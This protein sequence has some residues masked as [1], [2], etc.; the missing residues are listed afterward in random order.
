M[1]RA[2]RKDANHNEIAEAFSAF[3]FEVFDTSATGNGFPDMVVWRPRNGYIL[4][5]V[6]DGL[7]VPSA[8]RLT[9]AE[10]NFSRRFP[11][12]VVYRV[13]DVVEIANG[14]AFDVPRVDINKID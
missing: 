12:A 6:K 4:V 3:G 8:R 5:E 11:V 14:S 9:Q 7:K 13:S 2:R 10:D 1:S